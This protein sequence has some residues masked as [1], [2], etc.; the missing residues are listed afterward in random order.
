MKTIIEGLDIDIQP[1]NQTQ[2]REHH[3]IKFHFENI[4]VITHFPIQH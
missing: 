2:E 3:Y 4:L 1:D